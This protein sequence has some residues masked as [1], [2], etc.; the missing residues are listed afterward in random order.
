MGEYRTT[1]CPWCYAPIRKLVSQFKPSGRA[2]CS[3][4]HLALWKGTFA[5][6]HSGFKPG[7]RAW[8]EG[9]TKET[10]PI[11]AATPREAQKASMRRVDVRARASASHMGKKHPMEVRHKMSETQKTRV[12]LG[13]NNFY[14]DGRHTDT[15]KRRTSAECAAW[16]KQV[17]GR[18]DWTCRECGVRGGTLEAHHPQ[19]WRDFPALRYEVSNGVT[20]CLACHADVD[21]RRAAT[22]PRVKASEEDLI[23]TLVVALFGT[24]PTRAEIR[25]GV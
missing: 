11:I 21:P 16:R 23:S 9:L 25:S 3:R 1:S 19:S 24:H 18:D 12:A 7:V 20:L 22:L 6:A 14:I 15:K 5:Q 8:N 13:L 4:S 2:F 17:F 10:S